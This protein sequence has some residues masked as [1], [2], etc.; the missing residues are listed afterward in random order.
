MEQ[1]LRCATVGVLAASVA[2]SI[3]HSI[4]ISV[5]SSGKHLSPPPPPQDGG[6]VDGDEPPS[7]IGVQH[8]L[9]DGSILY[10]SDELQAVSFEELLTP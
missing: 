4:H 5:T 10:T 6:A 8:V 2:C 3:L 1:A 7:K 9:E